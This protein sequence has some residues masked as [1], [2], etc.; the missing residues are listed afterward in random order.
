MQL[1]FSLV[2]PLGPCPVFCMESRPGGLVVGD[3]PQKPENSF[4]PFLG[5]P[6]HNWCSSDLG[7]QSMAPRQACLGAPHKEP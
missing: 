6:G 5:V 1:L 7:F 3:V 4:S 2:F